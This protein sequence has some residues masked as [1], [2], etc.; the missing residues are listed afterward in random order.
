MLEKLCPP[1]IIYIGLMII[2]LVLELS[3]THYKEALI[4]VMVSVV[5]IFLLEALCTAGLT[6]IAWTI[7]FLPLIIYTYMTLIIFYVFGTDP[8]P[9]L[10]QYLVK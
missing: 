6:F 9:K 8:E 2:H 7:V 4:K 1:A 5:I 10:K 3:E